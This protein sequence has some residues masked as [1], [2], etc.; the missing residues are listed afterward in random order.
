VKSQQ[1]SQVSGRLAPAA[2]RRVAALVDRVSATSKLLTSYEPKAP[3]KRGFALV[4]GADGRLARLA[5]QLSVGEAIDLEF[6]DARLG[7]RV[8]GEPPFA[9]KPPP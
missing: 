2:E 1:A 6:A 7:A 5:G 9:L 4:W 8:D 3:L